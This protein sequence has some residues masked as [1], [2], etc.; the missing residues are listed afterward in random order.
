MHFTVLEQLPGKIPFTKCLHLQ[1]FGRG[2][3]VEEI[4]VGRETYI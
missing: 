4:L 3:F 2:C 1:H